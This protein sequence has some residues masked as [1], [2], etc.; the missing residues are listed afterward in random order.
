LD[1]LIKTSEPMIY[2]RLKDQSIE[3]EILVKFWFLP[4]FAK[5]VPLGTHL[6]I[7]DVFFLEGPKF[8]FR[9]ALSI[10]DLCRE[11]WLDPNVDLLKSIYSPPLDC[12]EVHSLL[13]TA[14]LTK[15]RDSSLRRLLRKGEVLA[16][17]NH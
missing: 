9:I 4:I 5:I 14:F 1:H 13:S 2:K 8:L 17:Q 10:L 7:L 15:I 3:T 11:I 16:K 6:R 12:L